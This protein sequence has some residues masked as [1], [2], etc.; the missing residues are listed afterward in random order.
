MSR[1][2]PLTLKSALAATSALALLTIAA[3]AANA[4]PTSAVK[5][6]TQTAQADKSRL[7]VADNQRANRSERR[8]ERRENR[9]DRRES[10]SETRSNR[11]EVRRD[12]RSDRRDDRRDNRSDRRS[13]RRDSNRSRTRT[14]FSF[15]TG[16]SYRSPGFRRATYTRPTNYWRS[17][18]NTRHRGWYTPYRSNLGI[19]FHFGTPGYSRYRWASNPFGFY[20]S[21]F[22]DYGY[23]SN[24]TTCR[25]VK[26]DGWH[27][28]RRALISVKQCSNPWDGSYIIQG[29]E[30]VV[31]TYW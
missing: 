21:S 28:A 8:S 20:N 12:S 26:L 9:S 13:D 5:S 10:R 18:Y 6:Q 31:R 22:G 29:S 7:K 1:Y 2:Q 24:R 15:S 11:R 4:A 23:Y 25:R 3:P 17:S 14:S 27:R 30:R 16:P 19:S